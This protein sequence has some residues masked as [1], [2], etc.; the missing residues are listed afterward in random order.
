M[1]SINCP[2]IQWDEWSLD[3]VCDG[4]VSTETWKVTQCICCI[5]LQ[6]LDTIHWHTATT[7]M[8]WQ[9][10]RHTRYHMQSQPCSVPPPMGSSRSRE[11]SAEQA[12]QHLTALPTLHRLQWQEYS[13]THSLMAGR[14]QRWQHVYSPGSPQ[15]TVLFQSGSKLTSNSIWNLGPRQATWWPSPS[16][17]FTSTWPTRLKRLD[18]VKTTSAWGWCQPVWVTAHGGGS[19]QLVAHT[20][21]LSLPAVLS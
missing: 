21:C 14:S 5:L 6:I 7:L 12:P 13:S 3:G 20:P 10:R 1:Q 11:V 16:S 17:G 18:M 15:S 19:T 8:W 9:W 4:L 2:V